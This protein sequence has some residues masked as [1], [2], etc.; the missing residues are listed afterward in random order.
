MLRSQ[1]SGNIL[2]H[3]MINDDQ[4]A[5]KSSGKTFVLLKTLLFYNNSLKVVAQGHGGLVK[6]HYCRL[7]VSN[8]NMIV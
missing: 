7:L 5:I 1:M 4:M 3:Y 2:F 6:G 8:H